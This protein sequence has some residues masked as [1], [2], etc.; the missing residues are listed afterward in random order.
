VDSIV[1]T[2]E[3][4]V[5]PGTPE[6]NRLIIGMGQIGSHILVTMC[7]PTACTSTTALN[8]VGATSLDVTPLARRVR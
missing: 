1:R 4:P 5:R 7:V 8:L 3:R 6:V 2:T